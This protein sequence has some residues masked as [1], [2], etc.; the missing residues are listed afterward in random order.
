MLTRAHAHTHTLTHTQAYA[1][2]HWNDV[3]LNSASL[4]GALLGADIVWCVRA[5]AR[6]RAPCERARAGVCAWAWAA[7]LADGW[8]VLCVPA[9]LSCDRR[10]ITR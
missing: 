7:A 1:D 6:A 8:P 10:A 2:D 5:R 3:V 4:V 9:G